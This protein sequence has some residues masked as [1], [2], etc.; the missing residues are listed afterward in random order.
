MRIFRKYLLLEIFTRFNFPRKS[1]IYLAEAEIS[2][3]LWFHHPR[4]MSWFGAPFFEFRPLFREQFEPIIEWLAF[5]PFAV[6]ET[7]V[8]E[9]ITFLNACLLGWPNRASGRRAIRLISGCH[10]CKERSNPCVCRLDWFFPRFSHLSRPAPVL[11]LKRWRGSHDSALRAPTANNLSLSIAAPVLVKYWIPFDW[12]KNSDWKNM[13]ERWG[14]FSRALAQQWRFVAWVP[15]NKWI[16]VFVLLCASYPIKNV[17]LRSS[18]Y[19][20]LLTGFFHVIQFLSGSYIILVCSL[21]LLLQLSFLEL[22]SAL[23]RCTSLCSAE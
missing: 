7:H 9:L 12:E 13:C 16:S 21:R 8:I 10:C 15:S 4:V 11:S 6:E 17:I 3:L 5:F 18:H 19:N 14:D 23:A 2:L 1:N 20:P 22:L